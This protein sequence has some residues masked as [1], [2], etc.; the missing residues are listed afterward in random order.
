MGVLKALRNATERGEQ[1]DE[2]R[3]AITLVDSDGDS[4]SV[5][6]A[7]YDRIQRY[8]IPM[9]RGLGFGAVDFLK[10]DERDEMGFPVFRE[11]D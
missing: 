1:S 9:M 7:Q 11:D 10:T 3:Y 4:R 2:K 6:I 8:R 5:W